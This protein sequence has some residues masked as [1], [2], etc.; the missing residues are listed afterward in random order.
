MLT[1]IIQTPDQQIFLCKLL[2]FDY[3]IKYK[4]GKDNKT[5]GA[6]SR[7]F[8]DENQN[9]VSSQG[10]LLSLSIIVNELVFELVKEQKH[11]PKL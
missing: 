2:G 3:V 9:E 8:E 5:D 4:P 7:K 1:Q 6:L 10:T 11:R